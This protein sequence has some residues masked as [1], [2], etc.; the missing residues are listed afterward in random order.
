[1]MKRIG[2]LLPLLLTVAGSPATEILPSLSVHAFYYAWYATTTVDGFYKHWNHDVF[3]RDEAPRAFP[4]GT[5][6]GANFF[7]QLGCYSSNDSSVI[8]T[9]MKQLRQAGIGVLCLSWWGADSFSDSAVA[10]ILDA[11]A[12]EGIEVCFHL[13]PFEGRNAETS[14][15]AIRT[16]LDR[17]GHHKAFH[18]VSAHGNRPLFYVY[19]SYLTPADEWATILAPA[20]ER[21]IRGTPYDAIVIALWVGE[22]DS[23]FVLEGH[24]DGFYTYF[25]TDGFTY[26]STAANWERLVQWARANGKISILCVGPGYSDTRIRP[27]NAQN[28]RGRAAGAYYDEMFETA[29]RAGPS[30]VGITSFNEWHE[31]TQIEPAVPMRT[32]DFTYEDY[33]PLEPDAYIARTRFWVE[34]FVMQRA[35]R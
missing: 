33:R 14:R 10:G 25:A 18:R 19:D 15:Q 29:L 22:D 7:P 27:W 8:A 21:T 2:L 12:R 17:Y 6:I 31:G 28:W 23:A 3:V 20:G 34:G 9:H 13:E 24:F 30:M 1:M 16:I 4:G 26:G 35:G 11:A 5:D 32:G